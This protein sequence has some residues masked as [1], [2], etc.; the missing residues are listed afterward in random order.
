MTLR[1]VSPLLR[2]RIWNLAL[3]VVYVAIAIVEIKDQG[4]NEPAL[5]ALASAGFTLYALIVWVG[6]HYIRHLETRLG[7][8]QA[9]ILYLITMGA[10]YLVAT[11]L[12]LLAEYV[13]LGGR[14]Y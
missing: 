7:S 4:R 1:L 14:F 12:Y 3:L 8:M 5:I 10:L 13:F 11:I 2:F 6:W 9:V